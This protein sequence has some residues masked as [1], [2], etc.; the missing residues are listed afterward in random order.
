VISLRRALWAIGI[1]TLLGVVV[2]TDLI[3][4]ADFEHPDRGLWIA[5]NAG[6]GLSFVGVGLFAWYRRPDTR[7]G[8]LMVATGFAWFVGNFGLTD[9]PLLFTLG[10]LLNNLFVAAA[11]HLFLAFPSGRLASRADRNLVIFAYLVTSV[12]FLPAMLTADPRYVGCT[13]CPE[14]L[15]LV[16]SN[17]SFSTTA[18][19]VVAVIG[20]IVLAAVLGRLI[21][22]W[23][24]A[25][26]P[27]RRVITPV[28]VAGGTLMAILAVAL[29]FSLLRVEGMVA[30]NLFYAALIPFG[31]VPYLFLAG[32]ARA[33]MLRG[34]A[35]SELVARIGGPLGGGELRDALARALNDPSLE[36]A[37]WLPESQFHVD[38]EGRR[39]EPP[40]PGSGRATSY[41]SLEGERV[42]VLVHDP[43]LL[44]EPELIEAVGAAAA[45][46]LE[47]ERL[48]AELRAKV[49]ELRESRARLLSI[50]LAERGRLERDLH[51]GAQQ[52]LVSL[53]LDLR[54]A[55]AAVRD[56]PTKAERLLD[57]AGRE[58]EHALGELRELARGIHPA[59]LSD[60]GLD[61]AVEALAR[62]APM[63][64]E[65]V[66][67]VGERMPKPVELAAYFVVSEALTN[68][69][70]Y[71]QASRAVVRLGRENGRVVVE[72]ADDGIGGADPSQGSGLRGLA[73]RVSA[74]GGRL[75]VASG[76]GEGTTVTAR[77]P[78]E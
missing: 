21:G 73:D 17:P 33:R 65:I 36:L 14:N 62:R 78:C 35:V 2:E 74:L 31:L 10:A 22:R 54:L 32:L 38:P 59:V 20:V 70:K 5:L 66:E 56:D 24:A 9:P 67:K 4:T 13:D 40:E 58:L 44:D 12:G 11:I 34:G 52:R 51:D 47:K 49:G 55:R 64:V 43:L 25:T 19:D 76:A 72:V 63:P 57:G 71:A 18:V 41:V 39:M 61:P 28:F 27:M 48:D 7:V 23:R 75:D 16:E 3:A 53:A 45:L 68:I 69:A 29:M 30:E 15:L 77:I 46:A 60:R 8:T 37:Y 42:A 26:P 6:I 1:A 50:E